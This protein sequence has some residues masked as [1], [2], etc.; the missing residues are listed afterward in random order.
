M[1]AYPLSTKDTSY[2]K[3]SLALKRKYICY[4][5]LL[6][7]TCYLKMISGERER[8]TKRKGKGEGWLDIESTL[9][10]NT[11]THLRHYN[12]SKI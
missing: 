10:L 12:M 6:F 4:K 3:K 1:E 2:M 9:F 11:F 5:L 7:S 8:K